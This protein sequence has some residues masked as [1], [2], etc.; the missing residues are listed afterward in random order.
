MKP[1]EYFEVASLLR[2]S[3]GATL[4]GRERSAISRYYY[5]AFLDARD[6]LKEKRGFTFRKHET[7]DFVKRAYAF[8]DVPRVKKLGRMLEDLKK[9]REIADYSIDASQDPVAAGEAELMSQTIQ[10]ELAAPDF[11]FKAC[12]NPDSRP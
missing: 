10:S 6:R 8:S 2:A 9:L 1:I 5:A 11:D 7:H 12:I 3:T 4:E